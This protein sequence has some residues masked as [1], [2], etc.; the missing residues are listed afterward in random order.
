MKYKSPARDL[1]PPYLFSVFTSNRDS[2][3]VH[4]G[5]RAPKIRR[6]RVRYPNRCHA[7][8]SERAF[9]SFLIHN[10]SNNFGSFTP[11]GREALSFAI[12]S[13]LSA[14]CFTCFG[15]TKTHRINVLESRKHKF[16]QILRLEF[17]GN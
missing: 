12:N 11:A 3:R 2:S 14:I 1:P 6:D 7:W 10:N 5:I 16:L 4:V 8:S 17:C 15:E 9:E 13:S